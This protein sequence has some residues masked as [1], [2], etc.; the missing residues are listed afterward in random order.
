MKRI[1]FSRTT[2]GYGFP[3]V[4]VY[5]DGHRVGEMFGTHQD[6]KVWRPDTNLRKLTGEFEARLLREAKDVVRGRLTV[7]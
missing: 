5:A 3:L 1:T 7:R 2:K 6:Q 4:E